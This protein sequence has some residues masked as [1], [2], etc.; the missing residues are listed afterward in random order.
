MIPIICCTAG[1]TDTPES[2]EAA[3]AQLVTPIIPHPPFQPEEKDKGRYIGGHRPDS[4]CYILATDSKLMM[5]VSLCLTVLPVPKP[6]Q[7]DPES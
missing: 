4:R 5:M 7:P 1:Y 6:P 2:P 3:K